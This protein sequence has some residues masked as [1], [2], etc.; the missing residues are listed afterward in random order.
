LKK[1]IFKTLRFLL[2]LSIAGILLYFAFRGIDFDELWNSFR[3]ANYFYIG[4]YLFFGFL[5]LLTRAY[6]WN[7]LIEP[8]NYKPSFLNSF[9]SL[10]TG[11]LANFAFPRLGELTRCV[12]LSRAEKI[13][14][15]KLF[16]TVIVE[17]VIDLIMVAILLMTL[18]VFRLDFFGTWLNENIFGPLVDKL[19]ESIGGAWI[20][21]VALVGIPV[22][23]I[24]IYY[25]FRNRLLQVSFIVKIKDFIKGIFDGLKTIYK[26][27]RRWAFIFHSILIWFCYWGMT[28]GAVFA[29]EETSVLKPIDGLFVLIVGSF[30]FILPAQGGI[31]AYHLITVLGLTLYNIPREPALTYATI[32]HGAQMIMLIVLGLISFMILFAVQRRTRREVTAMNPDL[33]ATPGTTIHPD[34]TKEAG[35]KDDPV[36]SD[37]K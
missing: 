24:A 26:L 13:P 17:R 30:G 16:G 3:T 35:T 27:K 14:V 18:I 33:A 19:N 10:N 5:S 31:G 37:A 7:I 21:I 23:M 15:D 1:K 34:A 36:I 9:Y 6:R 11:Y 28:Y 32:T 25:M 12:S 29:V 2:F 22:I 20:L 8:L 4:V